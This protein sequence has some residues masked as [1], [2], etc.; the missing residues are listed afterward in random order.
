MI[1]RCDD[2]GLAVCGHHFETCCIAETVDEVMDFNDVED[3]SNVEDVNDFEDVNNVEDVKDFEDAGIANPCQCQ[4]V[5]W[6]YD[7]Q[8]ELVPVMF[9]IDVSL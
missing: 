7:S 3:V 1:Y 8:D 5:C 6:E 9:H 4:G 2:C